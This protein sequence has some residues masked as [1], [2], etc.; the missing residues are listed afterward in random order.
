MNAER[1]TTIYRWRLKSLGI[2]LIYP[3]K[4]RRLFEGKGFIMCFK[5][6]FFFGNSKLQVR[7]KGV[8][9]FQ[10]IT[11]SLV[12]FKVFLVSVTKIRIDD[13]DPL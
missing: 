13:L 1:S 6:G 11:E 2:F 4:V 8:D 10:G 5:K 7:F 12:S 9:H 3:G